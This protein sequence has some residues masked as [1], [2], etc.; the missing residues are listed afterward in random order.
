MQVNNFVRDISSCLGTAEIQNGYGACQR[1]CTPDIEGL[2]PHCGL[3]LIIIILLG[4]RNRRN[5]I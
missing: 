4:A 3:L 5:T 2:G 1:A